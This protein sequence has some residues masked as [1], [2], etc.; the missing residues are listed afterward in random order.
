MSNRV[1]IP[2]ALFDTL[3]AITEPSASCI[4]EYLISARIPEAEKE[5]Q[6]TR[7]FLISYRGSADTYVS[8]RREVERILHWSWLIAKKPLKLLTRNDIRDYLTFIQKPPLSWIATQ[9]SPRFQL[10]EGIKVHNPAWR[11]FVVRVSKVRRRNGETP[12]KSIYQL[13]NKSLQALFAGLSTYFSFLQQEEYLENNPIILVRQ[14]NRY[15]QRQ[16]TTRVTR[17]LSHL[18]WQTVIETA[19]CLAKQNP[20]Y[21]RTLFLMSAFYLLGLRI[22]ELAETPGRIPN[23]GDFM[24]DKQGLWWFTTVGKGNKMREVAVPDA[25]LEALKRYRQHYGLTPLPTREEPTPLLFKQRGRGGLG[26]R[27]IR[28]LVQF[29]FNQAIAKLETTGKVDEAQDL[30]SATVHWLRHTAIS[31]D[32]EYR[33]REHIRDDVGHE[34]AATMDKYIDTDRAD[35]HASAK[36]KR[37]KPLIKDTKVVQE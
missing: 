6:L 18:Q 11:P 12:D 26:T 33:P 27:Q 34:N 15:I 4:N 14:K 10:K 17:K 29:C 7:E 13:G 3:E 32:I 8:Y 1:P 21:E 24:P 30:A 36:R 37:L 35:R 2:R 31:S 25:M 20:E 5:Y 9:N 28:N 19:E 23:M 16:Q 22:S